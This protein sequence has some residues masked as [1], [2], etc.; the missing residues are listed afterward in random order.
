VLGVATNPDGS[1]NYAATPTP[2]LVGGGRPSPHVHFPV[3][4][5]GVIAMPR[6]GGYTALSATDKAL[7]DTIRTGVATCTVCHG[8]PMGPG[9]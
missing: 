9:P 2:Y 5:N 1:R 7:E 8:D 4:P 3:W 6:D